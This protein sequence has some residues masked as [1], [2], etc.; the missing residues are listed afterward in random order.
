MKAIANFVIESEP[1]GKG[2]FGQ[3]HRCTH[4]DKKSDYYA[5][6]VVKKSSL[7]PRLFNNL[8]NEINILTKI[9]S[10]HVIRLTDIQ[11]TENNFYLVMELCNGGD[12]E[13][14]KALRGGRFQ[15]LEARIILQ[16]LVA[17]FKE[18]YKQQVMHRDLKLANIL[19]HLPEY[20]YDLVGGPPTMPKATKK[21][22][23][24]ELLK[25]VDL[26]ARG[27][28]QVK[29]ADL[30]FAR[31]LKHEDLSQTMCGTPLVMAPEVL[32]GK[33][34]NHKADVWSL[35]IVFFEMLVGFTPFTGNDK[36]DLKNNLSKGSYGVP[37][38]VKLSL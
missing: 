16:Q 37:K 4:K 12:L 19:V 28:M 36:A 33:R 14:L 11:R 29:I 1:L 34:Y 15:E 25:N 32:N 6:K 35:G 24:E 2:Q 17:G 10:P 38:G 13:N 9:N 23:A 8:K 18:I 30:G 5:V 31:E 27:R 21:V 3:V 26:T 20:P 22:Q 7:T